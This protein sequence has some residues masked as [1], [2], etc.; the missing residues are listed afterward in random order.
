MHDHFRGATSYTAPVA[1]KV[2]LAD[3]CYEPSDDDF[4]RLMQAAFADL[5]R[6]HEESLRQIRQRILALQ[7]EARERWLQ[8]DS[9]GSDS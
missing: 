6:A 8:R 1:A 7:L 3:P 9:K 2:N 4:A 5:P